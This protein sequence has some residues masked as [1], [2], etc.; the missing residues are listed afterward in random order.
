MP[1]PNIEAFT[2]LSLAIVVIATRVGVRWSHVSPSNFQVDDYLMPLVGVRDA[3]V[4]AVAV[5]P[6]SRHWIQG[7]K[8]VCCHLR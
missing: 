6:F 8:R 5:P 7:T 1:E 3:P 2:L 4:S